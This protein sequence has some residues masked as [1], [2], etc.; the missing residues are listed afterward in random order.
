MIQLNFKGSLFLKMKV[1][2]NIINQVLAFLCQVEVNFANLKVK[3]K[4]ILYEN[5]SFCYLSEVKDLEDNRIYLN[6]ITFN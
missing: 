4:N 1:N 5:E 2:F 3:D 6:I